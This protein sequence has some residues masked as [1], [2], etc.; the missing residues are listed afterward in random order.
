[1]RKVKSLEDVYDDCCASGLIRE[2]DI[3]DYELIRSLL[4]SAE[5]ERMML[6]DAEKVINCNFVLFNLYYDVLRKLISAFLLFERIKS[7]NHQ[8]L[9]AYLCIKHPDLDIDWKMLETFR[10]LR[11]GINYEGKDISRDEWLEQK[12][13][14][15][16]YIRTFVKAVS[17]KLKTKE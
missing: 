3:V 9:N 12:P 15:E 5:K 17:E 11:N 4:I 2:K 8:C 7:E 14:L 13:C 10:G 1:V 16:V 6:K